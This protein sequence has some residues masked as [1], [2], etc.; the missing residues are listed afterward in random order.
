MIY[1]ILCEINSEEE[2]EAVG[3]AFN[4]LNICSIGIPEDEAQILGSAIMWNKVL[5]VCDELRDNGKERELRVTYVKQ[6]FNLE[7][8]IQPKSQ[9]IM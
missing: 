6:E 8:F 7:K 9:E 1:R 4:A 5:S 3:E 2:L